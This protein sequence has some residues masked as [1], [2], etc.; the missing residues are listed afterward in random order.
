MHEDDI[1]ED[2]DNFEDL[3]ETKDESQRY[4]LA[5]KNGYLNGP[6]NEGYFVF[7]T[8]I[9]KSKEIGTSAKIVYCVLLGFIRSRGRGRCNPSLQRISNECCL[10]LRQV[11]ISI[12]ELRR[13]FWISWI[14]TGSSS[15]YRLFSPEEH[16]LLISNSKKHVQGNSDSVLRIMKTPEV[17][18]MP[19]KAV[20]R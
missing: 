16:E 17:Q 1:C 3:K 9:M 7:P 15:N 5:V 12:K 6:D 20:S 2:S 4:N 13:N 11:K 14:R 18:I 19:N 10:S 8:I